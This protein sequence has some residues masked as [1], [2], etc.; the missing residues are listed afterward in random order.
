MHLYG[1]QCTDLYTLSTYLVLISGLVS[2]YSVSPDCLFRYNRQKN[3]KYRFHILPSSPVKK[4]ITRKKSV[5][6][7][8]MLIL[9]KLKIM[10]CTKLHNFS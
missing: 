7:G 4:S 1:L 5:G 10:P 2:I 8:K 9:F 3:L 6:V